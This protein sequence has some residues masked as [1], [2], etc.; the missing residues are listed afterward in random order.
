[1]ASQGINIGFGNF[2]VAKRVVSIVN[3]SSS[4]MRKLKE[5]AKSEGRLIDVTQGKRT[6]SFIITDSNHL[7]LSSVSTDTIMQ[8]LES[9]KGVEE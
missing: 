7:I 3:P 2:V 4:P 9:V 8:R 5:E 1:M 6:R